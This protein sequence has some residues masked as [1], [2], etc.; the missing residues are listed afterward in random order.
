MYLSFYKVN[1]R[2]KKDPLKEGLLITRKV[3]VGLKVQGGNNLVIEV[4]Y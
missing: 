2:Q 4:G 1:K 3:W